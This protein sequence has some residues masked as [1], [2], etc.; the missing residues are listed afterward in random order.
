MSSEEKPRHNVATLGRQ[1]QSRYGRSF[2]EKS[3]H[4]IVPAA[5]AYS[6][7]QARWSVSGA[8]LRLVRRMAR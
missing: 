7:R 5:V 6:D 4:L 1:L 3:L 8:I 2:G